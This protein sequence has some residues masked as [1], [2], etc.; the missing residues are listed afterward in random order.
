[1]AEVEY[2]TTAQVLALT[3]V[4]VTETHCTHARYIIDAYVNENFQNSNGT[5]NV[6]TEEILDGSGREWLRLTHSP[7]LTV[8]KVEEDIG[9][10]DVPNWVTTDWDAD[11]YKTPTEQVE[12]TIVF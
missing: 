4:T 8:T 7:I 5:T 3:G 10:F 6:I 2:C 9:T 11:D 12:P 1:M